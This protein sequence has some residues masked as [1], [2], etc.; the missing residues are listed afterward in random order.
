[1]KLSIMPFLQRND[2]KIENILLFI[3]IILTFIYFFFNLLYMAILHYLST[4]KIRQCKEV[5]YHEEL[6]VTIVNH[7]IIFW[8]LQNMAYI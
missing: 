5:K 3:N 7:L 4:N 6:W 1:M 2:F 8:W